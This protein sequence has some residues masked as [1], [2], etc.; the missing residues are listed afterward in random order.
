MGKKQ[1]LVIGSINVDMVIKTKNIPI[2]GE[3]IIGNEFF[4]NMGGK[5]ANQA[6]AATRLG[7]EVSFVGKA[8][9][10]VFGKQA[11]DSLKKEGIDIRFIGMTKDVSSG[12]AT[13]TVDQNGENAI[14]VVPGAN[15]EVNETDIDLADEL[16][17]TC[18]IILLQYEIPIKIIEYIIQKANYFK[19]KVVLNPAPAEKIKDEY[20]NDLYIITPNETEAEK[21]TGVKITDEKT[22]IYAADLLLEK[23]IQIVIIT[24]GEK[25]A[26]V[27]SKNICEFISSPMVKAIDTTA[28]G[29]TFN[30]AL[31]VLLSEGRDILTATKLA[32]Q[33]A[34]LSVTR[35]GAQASIPYRRELE[36]L[37]K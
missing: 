25:G 5:G 10:D 6:I 4:M 35:F 7:G 19:K 8:G 37:N 9:N 3:T 18:E 13:I 26:L 17:D 2:P 23:G 27:K 30:G 24:L 36:S 29:D 20:L 15:Y 33:A 34:S 12:I 11:V 31:V 28:A 22:T 1:I 14:V 32:C 21:L 16:F